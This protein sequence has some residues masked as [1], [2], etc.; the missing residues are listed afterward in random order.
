[1]RIRTPRDVGLIIREARERL[2][3]SQAALAKKINVSQPWIS[4]V[5]RGKA[6]AEIGIVL[7]ALGALGVEM[8]FK[9]PS[10]SGNNDSPTDGPD[11]D[12]VPYSI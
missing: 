12:T 1:M 11:D 2:G 7:L 5:E 4:Q 10:A 3:M 8:D 9:I 6:T